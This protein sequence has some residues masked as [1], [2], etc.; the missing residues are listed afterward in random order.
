MEA[1]YSRLL[2]Y[3]RWADIQF[4]GTKNEIGIEAYKRL[5]Q[6]IWL[7][8]RAVELL[9][10]VASVQRP[11]SGLSPDEF[12][13]WVNEHGAE[14]GTRLGPLEDEL[15]IITECT[16]LI[17]WRCAGATSELMSIGPFK[18]VGVRDV[19]NKLIEHVDRSGSGVLL[20]SFG[21]GGDQGPVIRAL[22][23]TD[24]KDV[25]PDAG[26]F[27]NLQEFSKELVARLDRALEGQSVPP[28]SP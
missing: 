21:Y 22:R 18:P 13:A 4:N 14:V 5:R 15:E 10:Q 7:L 8:G 11:P 12:H 28:P 23:T 17:A 19:R 3:Y 26:L 27:V 6:T 2:D 16:Y 1:A 25:F 20:S 9:G 24:K